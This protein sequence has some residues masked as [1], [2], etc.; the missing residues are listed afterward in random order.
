MGT[1]VTLKWV[2]G[3]LR[4]LRRGDEPEAGE[5][6]EHRVEH[7]AFCLCEWLRESSDPGPT[8]QMT[9]KKWHLSLWIC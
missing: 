5:L 7:G 4:W 8:G 3:I 9:G 6:G 2:F 1:R